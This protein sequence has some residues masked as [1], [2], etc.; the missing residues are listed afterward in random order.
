MSTSPASLRLSSGPVKHSDEWHHI[1][2]Q[3]TRT[4]VVRPGHGSAGLMG[5]QAVGRG[6]VR[7]QVKQIQLAAGA[8]WAPRVRP[9]PLPQRV[10]RLQ[11]RPGMM[12]RGAPGT[13][14]GKAAI[15]EWSSSDSSRGSSQG[16]GSRG[17]E[18]LPPFIQ[19]W[20]LMTDAG[21]DHNEKNLVMTALSGNFDPQRVAQELRNQFP[22]TEVKKRDTS[23]RFQSY[24]GEELSDSEDDLDIPGNTTQELLDEGL[25]SEGAALI[26]D[27][28]SQAQEALAALHQ[29][30][31]TLKEARFKQHQVKQSRKYYS[32][33][34][35]TRPS[36]GS[37]GAGVRDDS[38]LDCLRC[39]QRGH[40]AANCPHKAI[41][42]AAAEANSVEPQQAPFV[43]FA[44]AAGSEPTPQF[45]GFVQDS[46]YKAYS[47]SAEPGSLTTHSMVEPHKPLAAWQLSRR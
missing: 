10:P 17:V 14:D 34:R 45:A 29:A 35:F 3:E 15:W 36:T 31:R 21:L 43:C 11:R 2:R 22:E 20:Y 24:L 30:R 1:T 32:T 40:R 47:V 28:E 27:A 44:T 26:V 13:P 38:N 37:S 19:G 25:T 5:S 16:S 23:K 42:S 12:Q 39:G 33:S 4:M 6:H 18:L 8:V 7:P 46:D 41:G 9:R